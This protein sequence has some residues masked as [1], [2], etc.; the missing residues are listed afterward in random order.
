MPRAARSLALPDE[1]S[2]TR[3]V[4]VF[5]AHKKSRRFCVTPMT[6][7]ITTTPAASENRAHRAWHHPVGCH[8]F[9]PMVD[10]HAM[11]RDYEATPI[12]RRRKD[13]AP[14]TNPARLLSQRRRKNDPAYAMLPEGA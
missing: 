7:G 6:P 8:A 1:D 2:Y 11:R 3:Q 12:R 4:M 9:L 13:M 14:K 5:P 10:K